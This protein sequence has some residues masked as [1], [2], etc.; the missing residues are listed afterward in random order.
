[1]KNTALSLSNNDPKIINA[2]IAEKA[3]FNHYGIE[4]KE[5]F[6]MLPEQQIRVRVLEMGDGEPLAMVPGNKADA[7]VLASQWLN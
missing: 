2:R 4:A 3:L 6:I 7:F 1:M 5:H